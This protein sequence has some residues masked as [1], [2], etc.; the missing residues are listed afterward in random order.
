MPDTIDGR[1]TMARLAEKLE[2]IAD[3]IDA[4][5]GKVDK[6]DGKVDKVDDKVQEL[7]KELAT[8]TAQHEDCSKY[9]SERWNDHGGLHS[10]MK[11]K[12]YI[13]D[14]LGSIAGLIAGVVAGLTSGK[15]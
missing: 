15:G 11:T 4:V 6:V 2:G 8:I 5:D 12:Q 10:D 13:G 1:V 3:K 7:G 14:G 9:Q